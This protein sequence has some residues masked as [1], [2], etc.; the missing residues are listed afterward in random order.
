MKRTRIT[1]ADIADVDNLA[2][3]TWKAARGKR[4]RPDVLAFTDKY[5]QNMQCLAMAI[6]QE[7]VPYARYRAFYIQDPKRRL[8]HAACFEDRILHHAILNLAETTF[9]R[10]LVD[11]SYACRPHKGVHRAISQVQRQLRRY[12]WY[13]KVDIAAYFPQIDHAILN[14]LLAKRF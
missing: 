8:I 2:L 1:L 5:P 13:V 4:H 9:E 11:S 3:A 6:L 7:Q 14:A 10:A 12:P